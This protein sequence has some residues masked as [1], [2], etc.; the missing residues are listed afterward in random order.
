MRL[1]QVLVNLLS[2]A[3]K[4]TL[5]EGRVTLSARLL[6][7]GTLKIAVSDSGIGMREDEMVLALQPFRQVESA[8]ARKHEG[9]GLGLPL[10]KA[11]A[12]MHGGTLSLHS[13]PGGGTTA[14]IV[15]PAARVVA[16]AMPR[17]VAG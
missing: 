2:N 17:K 16:A 10:V 12:E 4:F 14:G 9:T 3:V 11:F 15:L 8:L 6:G 7:N 5:A 1:K 13:V